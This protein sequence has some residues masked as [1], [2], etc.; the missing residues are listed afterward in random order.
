MTTLVL[1]FLPLE[2]GRRPLSESR[3]RSAM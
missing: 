2:V 1:A 3:V